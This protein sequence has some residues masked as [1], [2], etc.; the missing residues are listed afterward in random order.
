VER[1]FQNALRCGKLSLES[2]KF[3]HMPLEILTRLAFGTKITTADVTEMI[4]L[5][6]YQ[7]HNLS[8]VMQEQ[9]TR[10]PGYEALP[11]DAN[12]K[13]SAQA[14]AWHLYCERQK[15]RITED[16]ED[17]FAVLARQVMQGT[18]SLSW[19]ELCHTLYEVLLPHCFAC[20]R[21]MLDS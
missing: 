6:E 20:T 8:S 12:R 13:I 3:E 10:L 19:A 4:E 16:R 14:H 15:Q 9:L 11:T 1:F 2:A 18:A 17:L 5:Y 7:R 21:L